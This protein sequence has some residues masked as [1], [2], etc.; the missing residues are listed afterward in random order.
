M[1][2]AGPSGDAVDFAFVTA[3]YVSPDGDAVD[4][5]F[6][7]VGE[8]Y[9]SLTIQTS[10]DGGHGVIGLLLAE[11]EF[12]ILSAID[13]RFDNFLEFDSSCSA[14]Q[15]ATGFVDQILIE[16]SASSSG[17][18]QPIGT[19]AFNVPFSFSNNGTAG[20]FEATVALVV[21]M[22]AE[23]A[24]IVTAAGVGIPE[25]VFNFTFDAQVPPSGSAQGAVLFATTS[26]GIVGATG[27]GN[28]QP[29]FSGTSVTHVGRVGSSDASFRIKSFGRGG[30]G[31]SCSAANDIVF[32]CSAQG[33]V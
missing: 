8:A 18:A 33:S 31:P 17:A 10:A 13:C 24:G 16:F 30:F 14:E 26:S 7:P 4:F 28:A 20:N 6:S 22:V 15:P 1:S 2:Y 32:L 29:Q 9:V 19:S 23:S 27:V 12:F 3:V 25:V 5:D 21:E 11:P